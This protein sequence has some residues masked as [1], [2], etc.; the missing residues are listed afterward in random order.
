ML[1]PTVVQNTRFTMTRLRPGYQPRAVDAFLDRI[2]AGLDRLI[3]ENDEIRAQLAGAQLAGARPGRTGLDV[4][5]PSTPPPSGAALHPVPL[6]PVDVRFAQFALTRPGYEPREVDAFLDRIEAGLDGLIRENEE[7]RAPLAATRHGGNSPRPPV[8]PL[9]PPRFSP[10]ASLVPGPRLGSGP[11][12]EKA[13]GSSSQGRGSGFVRLL[14]LA[15]FF[16]VLAIAPGI[17]FAS[18]YSA[19]ERSSYTQ[20]SGLP[21][22][23]TVISE[24][25]GTGKAAETDVTVRLATPVGG[26]DTSVVNITGAHSYTSGQRISVLVDP[27]DPSYSEL[28]GLPDDL[29]LETAVATALIMVLL[30]AAVVASLVAAF[31]KLLRRPRD[32]R[33]LSGA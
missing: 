31:R 14:A 33:S 18:S 32:R 25:V 26:Q 24:K 27:R 17:A 13:G 5:A 2:G 1:T 28:P 10:P 6:T 22:S 19:F 21:D 4:L 12:P 9:S 15:L 23:A 8:S 30:T 29:P 3:R 11:G 7:I 20:A 16:A